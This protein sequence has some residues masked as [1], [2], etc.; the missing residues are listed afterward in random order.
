MSVSETIHPKT[1]YLVKTL[2]RTKRKD[3]ENYVINAIWH[4]L[5]NSDIQ[6]ISQQY[7]KNERNENGNSHYFIDLYF[8]DLNIGIECDEGYHSSTDQ[9]LKDQERELTIFD[10]LYEIKSD[11]YEAIHIDITGDFINLEKS[12]QNAVERIKE[13]IQEIKP[14]IWEIKTV[15]EFFSRKS[16]VSITDRIG[17]NSINKICN[18]LFNANRLEVSR[19]ATRA[20]FALPGFKGTALENHKLWFPKMAKIHNGKTIAATKTG[21]A[22]ELS[23]DG[24]IITERNELDKLYPSDG[25]KRIVFMKYRDPLG[26]DEYK[27][28]GI[29]EPYKQVNGVN[30][31]KR[32]RTEC[33]LIK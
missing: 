16:T 26:F 2:S 11:K 3:Y 10:V 21:W 4:K 30:H 15:E 5:S 6:V 7:I 12:I 1:S 29:F 20:Y 19:G 24:E 32:V 14:P 33:E 8:P 18:V 17:F 23:E 13:R 27:F 31:F 22:N 28:M 25:K 9:K